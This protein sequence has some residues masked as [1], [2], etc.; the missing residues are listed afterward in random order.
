MVMCSQMNYFHGTYGRELLQIDDFFVRGR[1][2]LTP[3]TRLEQ[4]S[5]GTKTLTGKSRGTKMLGEKLRG[6]KFSTIYFLR[7][8]R[9]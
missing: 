8:V 7:G 6:A 5:R 1:S 3:Y 9:Y 4:I 2:F